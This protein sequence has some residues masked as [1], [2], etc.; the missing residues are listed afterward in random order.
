MA[1]LTAEEE[2][3]LKGLLEKRKAPDA[4]AIGKTLNVTV[5]LGDPE[6]VARAQRL[7][8]LDLFDDDGDGDGDGAG[9]DDDGDE[10]P[11]RRGYFKGDAA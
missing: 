10:P 4:P 11:R 9:G 1:K 2:Q 3:T 7:G 5:D 8:L 6:Q